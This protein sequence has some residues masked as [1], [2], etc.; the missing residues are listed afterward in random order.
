MGW[1]DDIST[2]NLVILVHRL[3]VAWLK[4]DNGT[5]HFSGSAVWNPFDPLG[6]QIPSEHFITTTSAAGPK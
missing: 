4:A 3:S 5:L 1:R 6:E 2:P